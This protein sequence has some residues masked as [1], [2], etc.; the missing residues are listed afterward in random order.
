VP[1]KRSWTT[2]SCRVEPFPYKLHRSLHFP[3]WTA[4]ADWIRNR[5]CRSRNGRFPLTIKLVFSSINSLQFYSIDVWCCKLDCSPLCLYFIL[6]VK[7]CLC[8]CC[9]L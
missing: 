7:I 5:H 4:V 8:L 6:Y 9:T 2:I 3:L 1:L